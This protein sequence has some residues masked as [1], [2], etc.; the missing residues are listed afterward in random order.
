MLTPPALTHYIFVRRDLPLG[1][2]AAQVAHAA[3]ESFYLL[4]FPSS[5]EDRAPGSAGRSVVQVH[6]WEPMPGPC[7]RTFDSGAS[8][9]SESKEDG[10]NP[11]PGST[12]SGVVQDAA[13]G[14]A[15]KG[16]GEIAGA[17]SCAPGQIPRPH[18]VV[19]GV[20]SEAKL[21]TL[22]SKLLPAGV[23]HVAVREPDYP[24]NGQLMAIGLMP[25]EREAVRAFTG[26]YQILDSPV[27]Q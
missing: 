17:V 24:F 6:P 12:L 4:S 3:G 5:S 26:D 2:I 14:A 20:R 18:V 16:G 25:C 15:R 11:S 21:F 7:L 10:E 13:R 23:R 19:L 22:E 1:V 9:A 27:G 8:G